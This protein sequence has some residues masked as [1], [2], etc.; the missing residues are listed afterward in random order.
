MSSFNDNEIGYCKPPQ[1]T[2]F[3]KGQS[4]NLK[5]RPK[6][7][8]NMTT[9][10]DKVLREKV[11]MIVNGRRKSLTKLEIAVKQL[12][13][14]AVTGDLS[15]LKQLSALARSSEERAIAVAAMEPTP[16]MNEIDKKVLAGI[17]RR[18]DRS[19]SSEGGSDGNA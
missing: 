7:R 11:V 9:V 15:A 1:H 18:F 3:R 16:E 13:N 4:G 8:P 14:K 17:L 19:S 2:Q 12:V 10:L 6:G 5:G